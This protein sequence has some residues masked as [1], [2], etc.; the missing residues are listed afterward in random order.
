MNFKQYRKENGLNTLP[1]S[2]C[3][4]RTTDLA[5][6]CCKSQSGAAKGKLLLCT[7]GSLAQMARG[8]GRM[9]AP[10]PGH[11]GAGKMAAREIHGWF[12]E[13]LGQGVGLAGSSSRVGGVALRQLCTKHLFPNLTQPLR[14]LQLC[15]SKEI[16]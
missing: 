2:W 1:Q 11:T 15:R 8:P 6:H 10:Q 13:G 7:V 3:G 16:H 5:S 14:H 12:R 4:L 9:Q